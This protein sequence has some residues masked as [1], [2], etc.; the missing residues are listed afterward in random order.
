MSKLTI[1]EST[2]KRI[3]QMA[4][5]QDYESEVLT[6]GKKSGLINESGAACAPSKKEQ[7]KDGKGKDLILDEGLDEEIPSEEPA[8]VDDVVTDV[9]PTAPVEPEMTPSVGGGGGV[10]EDNFNTFAAGLVDLFKKNFDMN[11]TMQVNGQEVSPTVDSEDSF[12]DSGVDDVSVEEPVDD[13]GGGP[14]SDVP[15][16]LPPEDNKLPESKKQK[17]KA[18][19]LV[20]EAVINKLV[21]MAGI[22]P[23]KA[24]KNGNKIDLKFKPKTK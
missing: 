24:K 6:E 19:Q 23:E 7:K 5:L 12:T 13:F 15:S 10:L 18:A 17:S 14:E 1:S 2:Q 22:D 3:L 16:D 9:E 4:G 21:K 11:V 8:P 20:Y